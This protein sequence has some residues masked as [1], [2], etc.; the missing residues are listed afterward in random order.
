MN[1]LYLWETL[2]VIAWISGAALLL[3]LSTL[4]A[5][6]VW[7]QL[8]DRHTEVLSTVGFETPFMWTHAIKANAILMLLGTIMV[9][10]G[11]SLGDVANE[12]IN[13]VNEYEDEDNQKAYDSSDSGYATAHQQ[14]I[15]L[16]MVTA[17]SGYLLFLNITIGAYIWSWSFLSI[18]DAGADF[19]C[20][21]KPQDYS[22]LP[23]VVS[24]ITSK[25]TCL[26][27][28]D[29]LFDIADL[30]GDNYIDRCEDANF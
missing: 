10:G 12:M 9:I 17:T 26:E 18:R 3:L 16:H 7:T 20:E 8:E 15:L 14:D 13:W 4:F 2:L 19:E 22:A 21:I 25:E 11:F 28:I 27:Q 30:N 24:Q 5:M 23:G 29:A 1:L 6:D